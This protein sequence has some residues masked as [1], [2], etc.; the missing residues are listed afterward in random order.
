MYTEICY[1]FLYEL[2]PQTISKQRIVNSRHILVLIYKCGSNLKA[3]MGIR[4]RGYLECQMVLLSSLP[5]VYKYD[6]CPLG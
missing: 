3:I 2:L 5:F 1:N 4:Y 6:E